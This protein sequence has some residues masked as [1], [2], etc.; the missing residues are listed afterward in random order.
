MLNSRKRIVVSISFLVT[1]F[2]ALIG[3]TYAY[4]VANVTGN[5]SE[6]PSLNLRSGYLSITYIDG[7]SSITS[8]TNGT[9][10]DGGNIIY[11]KNFT[12]KNSGVAD[13][14]YGVWIKNYKVYTKD[15]EG[16]KV[17]SYFDRPEDWTY[18]LSS[19]DEIIKTGEF[20]TTDEAIITAMPLSVNEIQE[21]T[22][23]V[24]Y[25][26]IT[27]EEAEDLGLLLEDVNQTEDMNKTL[28]FEVSVTQSLSN[29][30]SAK[31]GTLLYALN[32]DN[33]LTLSPL[34]QPGII[35]SGKTPVIGTVD[36]NSVTLYSGDASSLYF[37]YTDA[38]NMIYNENTRD[39]TL[40]NTTTALYSNISDLT[41]KYVV[42]PNGSYSS[43][44]PN[45]ENL[46]SVYLITSATSTKI[47]FEER[48]VI[49]QSID[50]A[51]LTVALDDYGESYYYRGN[52]TNNYVNYSG[53]CWRIVRV[54]GDGTI[55]LVLADENNKCDDDGTEDGTAYLPD[56]SSTSAFIYD[57]DK[58]YYNS[59]DYS[60]DY[61]TGDIPFYIQ[62]WI[63]YKY[64]DTYRLA[65]TEWCH[66][67]SIHSELSYG[68]DSTGSYTEDLGNVSGD[69]F[70]DTYY[71]GYG[72]LNQDIFDE[73]TPTLKCNQTGLNGS[74]ANRIHSQFGL[75]TADEIAFAGSGYWVTNSTTYLRA[76][77]NS[78]YWTMTPYN[79]DRDLNDPVG[80]IFVVDPNVMSKEY[81]SKTFAIRPVVVLKRDVKIEKS[82]DT[83]TYGEPGTQ[84]NPY[85]IG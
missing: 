35:P 64:V 76:N 85:V 50:E 81:A 75:L 49:Y 3:I 43:E 72:R 28:S 57:S 61:L 38:E 47:D 9:T 7:S 44:K 22:L 68:Y 8:G 51:I 42:N 16:K 24:T 52:V 74:K 18:V 69:I 58:F 12:V 54:Q 33:I 53:M 73:I 23:T 66:D 70:T 2:I 59:N 67:T 11:T 25:N 62:D 5:L 65:K 83:S 37:T 80:N 84:N 30:E 15:S 27:E 10:D 32:R 40:K 56:S 39:F 34:S 13:S 4:Y 71:G 82:K 77:A 29:L 78:T 20:P 17:D 63:N 48:K 21:L 26:Y 36:I 31:E 19:G 60:A 6:N 46:Y 14:Y 1:I 79:V 41:G 45:T 55:K